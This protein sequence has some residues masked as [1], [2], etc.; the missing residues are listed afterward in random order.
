MTIEEWI[1]EKDK[2]INKKRK[3]AAQIVAYQRYGGRWPSAIVAAKMLD[4]SMAL[5]KKEQSTEANRFSL[6]NALE[7]GKDCDWNI[8]CIRERLL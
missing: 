3:I 2:T 7:I 5:N 1:E 8:K 6:L 4:D